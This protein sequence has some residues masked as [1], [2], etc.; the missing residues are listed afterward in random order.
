MLKPFF[1]STVKFVITI[2][3]IFIFVCICGKHFPK[4]YDDWLCFRKDFGVADNEK[5]DIVIDNLEEVASTAERVQEFCNR[6]G[7]AHKSS[8]YAALSLEE[9][10][11]NVVLHGFSAD[12]KKHTVLVK[13]VLKNDDLILRIKDDCIPFDPKERAGQLTNN[14]PEKNIGIRMV[15]KLASEMIYQN[16]LGLNV[17]TIR[18]PIK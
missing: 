9:M 16:L 6:H 5:L 1:K 4:S 8:Y 10:A 15:T 11:G 17:L 7:I 14:E 3:T 18:F 12:K 2:L 13:V